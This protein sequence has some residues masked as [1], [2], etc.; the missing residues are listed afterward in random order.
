[1]RSSPMSPADLEEIKEIHEKYFKDQFEFPNFYRFWCALVIR[2]DDGRVITA[3]GVR[4]IAEL[5]LVTDKSFSPKIRYEALKRALEVAR[6]S[7]R[8]NDMDQ[9]HAFIQ[10]QAWF[11]QLEK[12]GFSSP[13][14]IPLITGV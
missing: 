2:D 12:R 6:L 3:G 10:D 4:N 14:G 1:M 8:K 5:V 13:V 7:A 9:L 11:Q